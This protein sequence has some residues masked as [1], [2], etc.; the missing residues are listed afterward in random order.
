M[1][2]RAGELAGRRGVAR[3]SPA[4]CPRPREALACLVAWAEGG[5]RPRARKA[6]VPLARETVTELPRTVPRSL[7]SGEPRSGTRLA[8]RRRSRVPLERVLAERVLAI[9]LS[10]RR[11]ARE[12][13]LRRCLVLRAA[14]LRGAVP[15][16]CGSASGH[17]GFR[18]TV[19]RASETR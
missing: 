11:A 7:I 8:G 10:W 5:T 3:R 17:A 2:H 18:P 13:A 19:A 16:P 12:R 6:A 1:S 9:L 4:R 15:R 14:R